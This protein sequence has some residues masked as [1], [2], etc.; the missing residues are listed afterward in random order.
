MTNVFVICWVLPIRC[1]SGNAELISQIEKLA[2][3]ANGDTEKMTSSKLSHESLSSFQQ[4]TKFMHSVTIL[5]PS[6]RFGLCERRPR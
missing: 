6:P 2:R 4:A 1:I 5:A 3:R